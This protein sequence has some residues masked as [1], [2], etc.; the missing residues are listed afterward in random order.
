VNVV[1]LGAVPTTSPNSE[2]VDELIRQR[3]ER[4]QRHAQR[5]TPSQRREAIRRLN[6]HGDAS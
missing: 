4:L 5:L 6:E 1:E 3:D 2:R